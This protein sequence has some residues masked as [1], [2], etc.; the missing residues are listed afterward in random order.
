M[1][2]FIF[3]AFAAAL[4]LTDSQ[5]ISSSNV[6]ALT[7][8]DSKWMVNAY[9]ENCGHCQANM[10]I[11]DEFTD[12]QQGITEV[13]F[14]TVECDAQ[15]DICAAFDRQQC[16]SLMM[17]ETDS[18]GATTFWECAYIDDFT[19]ARLETCLGMLEDQ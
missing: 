1:K 15:P 8:A 14:G 3:A 18:K 5:E 9:R 13:Y 19:Q 11:W 10:P 2:T 16:P 6:Q 12:S 4:E 7:V 17:I